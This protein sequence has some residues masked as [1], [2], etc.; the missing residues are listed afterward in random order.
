M[1]TEA[2][3]FAT[4]R[5]LTPTEAAAYLS[6]RGQLTRTFAWQ[7]LWQDEHAQQFTVSRL[8]RLD[9]LQAVRDQIAGSVN[10][11]LSRRDFLRD[12]KTML[13]RAGWWGQKTVPDPVAGEDVITRFDPAR[14]KLI[15]D[16]NKIGRAHV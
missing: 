8:A 15:Y 16:T 1:A 10:G 4:L 3:E 11:D 9:L 2:Q 6:R 5:T 14:L 12:V 7:D 13:V